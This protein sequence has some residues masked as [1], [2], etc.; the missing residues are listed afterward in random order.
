VQVTRIKH[1]VLAKLPAFLADIARVTAAIL[2]ESEWRQGLLNFLRVNSAAAQER[3][4]TT[5]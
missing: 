4:P 1:G 3:R 5:I 2:R